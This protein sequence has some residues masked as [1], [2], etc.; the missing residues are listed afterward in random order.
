MTQPGFLLSR[1]CNERENFFAAFE[2]V[3][4]DL[5]WG[6]YSQSLNFP[7]KVALNHIKY[8]PECTTCAANHFKIKIRK[9]LWGTAPSPDPSPTGNLRTSALPPRDPPPTVLKWSHISLCN[10]IFLIEILLIEI[11][12]WWNKIFFRIFRFLLHPNY[13]PFRALTLLVGRQNGHPAC[14]NFAPKPLNHVSWYSWV[15]YRMATLPACQR[16]REG[17]QLTQVRLENGR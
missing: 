5:F 8:H 14:I 17:I 12:F 11:L 15:G 2:P 7:L 4:L 9:K 13:W 3:V 10:I 6:N 1:N 16:S